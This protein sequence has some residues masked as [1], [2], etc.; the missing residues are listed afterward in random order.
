MSTTAQQGAG[1]SD[2]VY[3]NLSSYV[4]TKNTVSDGIGGSYYVKDFQ[5]NQSNGF[6]A[7]VFQNTQTGQYVITFRG[8]EPSGKDILTDLSM[9]IGQFPEQFVNASD[10]IDNAINT[11]GINESNT[12]IVGHSL[13]GSLAE[14]GGMKTGFQ[15]YT[16][17]AYGIGNIYDGIDVDKYQNIDNYITFNDFVSRLPTSEMVGN[18]HVVGDSSNDLGYGHSA[19]NFTNSNIW[20]TIK[21]IDDSQDYGKSIWSTF[22][23]MASDGYYI[24]NPTQK[25]INDLFNSATYDLKTLLLLGDA[26]GITDE[27][28]TAALI[29]ASVDGNSKLIL[30][31][32]SIIYLASNSLNG[33]GNVVSTTYQNTNGFMLDKN[34]FFFDTSGNLFGNITYFDP[35]NTLSSYT[36]ISSVSDLLES[37]QQNMTL[38]SMEAAQIYSSMFSGSSSEF[39]DF[40]FYSWDDKYGDNDFWLEKQ[41]DLIWAQYRNDS[42]IIWTTD[43]YMAA[44]AIY[45]DVYFGDYYHDVVNGTTNV[46]TD[47]TELIAYSDWSNNAGISFDGVSVNA[48]YGSSGGGASFS[49]SFS[50]PVV[51]DLDGDGVELTSVIDSKAWFDI[52]G[53]GTMHQTGWVGADDGLLVFD[54][55]GDGKITTARE[56]AFADRTVVDD[57]DLESLRAEFDS[58]NDGKL[59]AGDNEFGKFYIWQDKNSDGE[60]DDGELL[61]LPQAGI[62]SIDLIGSKID[63]YMVDGNKINAFTTYIRTDGTVGMGADVALAYDNTGYTTGSANGYMT[64]RQT[65]SEAVYAMATS[66]TPLVLD[67]SI[68]QLDGAIGNQGNDTLDASNKSTSVILEGME[69]D[70]ILKGGAGDDWLDGG[71]GVD[72]LEGGKGSDTYVVDNTIELNYIKESWVGNDTGFDTVIYN[73]SDDLKIDIE[74]INVEAIYSGSGNDT[75]VYAYN[76]DTNRQ[77]GKGYLSRNLVIDGGAGDDTIYGHKFNDLLKGELGNDILNGRAG[78]DI[79]IF[80]R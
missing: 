76:F 20:N 70:D 56:I 34:S 47:N 61:T 23:D 18:V 48:S 13:G 33:L 9:G 67:L 44:V 65:G 62:S 28:L 6:A 26:S 35:E 58:N 77:Y 60:S 5:A 80:N 49:I 71:E 25:V 46:S 68:A 7:A 3:D 75:I 59:D 42:D 66:A 45:N 79:F 78:D 38:N 16:Y 30:D 11:Y 63:P 24:I 64:I 73:G 51:L 53:D 43:D 72:K 69:G 32:G 4:G 36:S 57:T 40:L 2:K 12:I 31:D 14:Y 19:S 1:L 55:N 54:E 37:F 52:A 8:T 39:K 10:F 27:D 21:T 22:A 15:T 74:R 41:N 50:F 17:N 29:M